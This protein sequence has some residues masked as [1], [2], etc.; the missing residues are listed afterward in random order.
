[1]EGVT[2]HKK[3]Y[4]DKLKG[5]RLKG[6]IRKTVEES[7]TLQLDIDMEEQN[8][9]EWPW[10][11]EIGNICY[12]MPEK[13]TEAMLYFPSVK[14]IDGIALHQIRK[15]GSSS[16]SADH[17]E[18]IT[19]EKK[20]LKLHP[21]DII[22]V[23]SGES[24]RLADDTGIEFNS[25]SKISLTAAGSIHITGEKIT[26]T[27]P[28]RIACQTGASNIEICKSFNF[29]APM[30]VQKTEKT[31]DA[32]CRKEEQEKEENGGCYQAAFAAL[33]AIPTGNFSMD[34]SEM[35]VSLMA[36]GSVPKLGNGSAA[37]S[38]METMKGN[39]KDEV[40]FPDALG[41]ME[42]YTNNG[43]FALPKE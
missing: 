35:E 27:A 6:V 40:S 17:K 19:A 8:D 23:T 2:Y 18:L 41:S 3:Q 9:Y 34:M 28:N 26:V 22:F 21:K 32:V 5:A 10:K 16:R 29:Y 4:A 15:N 33:A 39:K 13:G 37:F 38:M 43:S 1:M 20:M 11:P 25:A 24:F 31:R 30:G 12:L 36:G 42:N 7:V 14:E